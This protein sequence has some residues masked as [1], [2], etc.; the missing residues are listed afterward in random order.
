MRAMR[1]E[2]GGDASPGKNG[3]SEDVQGLW[4]YPESTE[5]AERWKRVGVNQAGESIMPG[6]E[7]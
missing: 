3:Q 4:R 1:Q 7:Q 2:V 6:V 5:S